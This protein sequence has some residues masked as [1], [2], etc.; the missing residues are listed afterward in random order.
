M[1]ATPDL[2]TV[3][4]DASQEVP[5]TSADLIVVVKG[6]SLFSG[7][8]A[9]TKAREIRQLVAD[10]EQVR[11]PESAISLVSVAAET[12]SGP[13]GKS[14]AASYTLL[15]HIAALD[16]LADAV[17]AIAAQKNS[18]LQTVRWDYGELAPIEDALLT[19][20]LRRAQAK[21]QLMAQT[22]GGALGGVHRASS[23]L[24]DPEDPQPQMYGGARGELMMSRSMTSDD[25]GLTVSHSKRLALSVEVA[26][27]IGR[28]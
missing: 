12:A 5:A 15:V 14:S 7:S 8:A 25:L 10:L 22:L 28:Q 24:T 21:A 1:D 20:A 27:H 13:L 18:Q 6:A 4:A 26:Y 16:D 19:R 2:L 3:T 17:G 11:V 9:L 23:A